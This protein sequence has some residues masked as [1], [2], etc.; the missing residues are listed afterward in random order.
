V[1][2]SLVTIT[3]RGRVREGAILGLLCGAVIGLFA[4]YID[5]A[6]PTTGLGLSALALLAGFSVPRVFAFFDALANRIFQPSPS[7][8][9]GPRA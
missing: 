4:G 7:N 8:A 5:N 3:D 2:L 6:T 1:D 9:A